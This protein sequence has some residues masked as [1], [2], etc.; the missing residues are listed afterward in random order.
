MDGGETDVAGSDESCDP[1][2]CRARP[3]SLASRISQRRQPEEGGPGDKPDDRTDRSA[4]RVDE[5]RAPR[6]QEF[7]DVGSPY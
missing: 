3:T 2:R 7:C 1:E 6:G 4:W 5:H